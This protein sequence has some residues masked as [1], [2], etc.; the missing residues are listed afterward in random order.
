MKDG[1]VFTIVNATIPCSDIMN[2]IIF[3]DK[4]AQEQNK[5]ALLYLINEK[6]PIIPYERKVDL[7]RKF[8]QKY[9]VQVVASKTLLIFEVLNDI[10]TKGY[11]DVIGLFGESGYEDAIK[12]T[13]FNG[14]EIPNKKVNN[15]LYYKFDGL[16]ILQD[17]RA[18][19]E[20]AETAKLLALA[21]KG[22][23]GTFIDCCS[24]DQADAHEVFVLIRQYYG[25]SPEGTISKPEYRDINNLIQQRGSM[26]IPI[27]NT[28][29]LI[30]L[31]G[32]MALQPI[33]YSDASSSIEEWL[34]TKNTNPFIG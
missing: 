3:L 7:I 32:K 10:W 23:E 21:E 28:Q 25:L 8:L 22:D 4:E 19:E 15:D 31:Q 29:P 33:D 5:D 11:K 16:K 34:N 18:E 30:G 9:K 13:S 14:I 26:I 12:G 1:T 24:L 20:T 2:V 6:N 17:N 27:S